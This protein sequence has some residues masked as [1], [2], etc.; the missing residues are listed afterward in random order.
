MLVGQFRKMEGKMSGRPIRKGN[1]CRE[2]EE[3]GGMKE[4]H[5]GWPSIASYAGE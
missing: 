2:M 4:S 1:I 5:R 3:K